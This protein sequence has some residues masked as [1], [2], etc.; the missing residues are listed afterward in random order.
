MNEEEN[1]QEQA[2]M[3]EYVCRKKVRALKIDYIQPSCGD[4]VVAEGEESDGGAIMTPH[5]HGYGPVKVD[6][7]YLNKHKPH[8]GGYYVVY[9]DEYE[10]YFPA[11]AFE[12]EYS[13]V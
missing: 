10:S 13:P 2:E 1:C 7:E 9:E 3:P 8:T 4:R 12:K 6:A 11:A 5:E